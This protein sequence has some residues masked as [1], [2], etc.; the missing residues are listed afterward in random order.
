M[1]FFPADFTLYPEMKKYTAGDYRMNDENNL[2]DRDR[3]CKIRFD[4]KEMNLQPLQKERF[5]FLLGPRYNP[6]KP[7]DIKIVTKQYPTYLENYFKGMD[8]IKELYWEA[9][10]APGDAVNFQR[11]PYLREQFKKRKFGKTR[12]ERLAKKA[13][14]NEFL[15]S[16]EQNVIAAE[17][18][19]AELGIGTPKE[20]LE[21]RLE[22]AKARRLLGFMDFEVD[23]SG[24]EI[25]AEEGLGVE[26]KVM[27]E[28]AVRRSKYDKQVQEQRARKQI[29]IVTPVQGISRQE[30]KDA[31]LRS[32]EHFKRQ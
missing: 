32:D 20:N 30:Y 5:I 4:L 16:N 21:Q 27:Q 8:T 23:E 14:I 13:Q 7:Y 10:R 1:R 19:D 26:D 2:D 15:K 18:R 3:V 22:N 12:E 17:K 28:L 25:P 6:K 9:L 24:K 31:M 29:D 11:D